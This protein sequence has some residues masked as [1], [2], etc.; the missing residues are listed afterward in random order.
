[1][2]TAKEEEAFAKLR[3]NPAFAGKTDEQ[4]KAALEAAAGDSALAIEYLFGDD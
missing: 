2:P 4:I 1:M 3:A